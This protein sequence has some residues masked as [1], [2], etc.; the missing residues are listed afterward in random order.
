MS[1]QVV[2]LSLLDGN[3]LVPL[4]IVSQWPLLIEETMLYASTVITGQLEEELE[5]VNALLDAT[6]NPKLN[7]GYILIP[8]TLVNDIQNA[9]VSF[10][11]EYGAPIATQF[12]QDT[13][14]KLFDV[15]DNYS[16]QFNINKT[17][18]NGFYIY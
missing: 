15:F 4:S 2:V 9:L 14:T 8:I 13:S 1:K 17:P 7:A 11:F 18:P 5:E 3:I 12:Y 6:P 16:I 10:Q